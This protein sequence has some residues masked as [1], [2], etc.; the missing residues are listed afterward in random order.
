MHRVA[1][2][3]APFTLDET[4]DLV[5]ELLQHYADKPDVVGA[6]GLVAGA[7]A[8]VECRCQPAVATPAD[9]VPLTARAGSSDQQR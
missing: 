5:A 2:S 7:L 9:V 8:S 6:L 1:A 3:T 4:R